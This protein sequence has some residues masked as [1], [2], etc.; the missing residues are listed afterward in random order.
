MNLETILT[1][2]DCW[3]TGSLSRFIF[4]G[5][6]KFDLLISFAPISENQTKWHILFMIKKT[7]NLWLDLL[8]YIVFGVQNIASGLHDKIIFD[9]LNDNLGKA[10]IKADQPVLKFRQFYQSWVAKVQ[11]N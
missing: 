11:S 2:S 10:F 1:Y 7:G 5:Q 3:P 4:N 6:P 9:T 8:Y